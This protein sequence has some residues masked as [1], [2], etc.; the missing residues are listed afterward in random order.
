MRCGILGGRTMKLGRLIKGVCG[1]AA[2]AGSAGAL[3]GEAMDPELFAKRIE[4]Q[5]FESVSRHHEHQYRMSQAEM[6][7]FLRGDSLTDAEWKFSRSMARDFVEPVRYSSPKAALE[8]GELDFSWRGQ[9]NL[10]SRV[11]QGYRRGTQKMTRRI[12]GDRI[13]RNLRVDVVGRP[14]IEYRIRF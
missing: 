9:R 14:K 13:S 2:I 4:T 11:K 7:T 12:V 1:L 8:P 6:N 3:A 5:A 10:A